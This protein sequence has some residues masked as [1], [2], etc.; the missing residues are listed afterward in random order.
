[1]KTAI[2]T[3]VWTSIG[4]SAVQTPDGPDLCQGLGVDTALMTKSVFD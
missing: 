3:G 2:I 4:R 1:M